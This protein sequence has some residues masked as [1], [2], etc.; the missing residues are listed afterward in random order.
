MSDGRVFRITW[1]CR[2]WG[3]VR[4]YAKI[5]G[6]QAGS[7]EVSTRIGEHA[8]KLC[9]HARISPGLQQHPETL[10]EMY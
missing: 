1:G 2:L 6:L 10:G 5:Q 7:G 8:H 4:P 9:V 3:A